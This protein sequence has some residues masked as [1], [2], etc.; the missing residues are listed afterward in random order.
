MAKIKTANEKGKYR[1]L[2]SKD[3]VIGYVLNP[4]KTPHHYCGYVMVNPNNIAGSMMAVSSN[5]HKENGV[6][7]R[8]FILSFDPKELSGFRIADEIGY[9]TMRF[10]GKEYQTIYAVHEKPDNPHIHIVIN[11]VSYV[12]GHR[13][14]GT[15]KEFYDMMNYLRSILF[16]YGIKELI[17]VPNDEQE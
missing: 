17:Y 11:S 14:Y 2:E 8:H 4:Y 3:D 9:L 5:F 15:R 1:D 13:Y 16:K 10:F 6:Q 12:D 7:I